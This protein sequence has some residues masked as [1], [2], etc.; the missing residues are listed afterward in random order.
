[1][2]QIVTTPI[3]AGFMGDK[4]RCS[5]RPFS[6]FELARLLHFPLTSACGNENISIAPTYRG[7][8]LNQPQISGY[9]GEEVSPIPISTDTTITST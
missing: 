8:S 4:A 9:V 6:Q 2:H 3:C 5:V 1:M 7:S